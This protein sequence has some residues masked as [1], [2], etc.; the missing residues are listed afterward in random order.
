VFC[1]RITVKLF[2]DLI[3]FVLVWIIAHNWR[4]KLCVFKWQSNRVL[5]ICDE[6]LSRVNRPVTE[7]LGAQGRP[8]PRGGLCCFLVSKQNL[9]TSYWCIWRTIVFG[10]QTKL[11][12]LLLVHV[13]HYCFWCPNKTW[14]P[15][16]GAC[17]ALLFLVSKQNL[18][19]SYW[20][21]WR[22]KNHQK[23]NRIEKV[24]R[25]QNE[26]RCILQF[27]KMCFLYSSFFSGPLALHVKDEL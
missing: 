14:I 9:N 20:C 6:N 15:P 5:R 10:V 4:W 18:N 12:Y 19:T 24:R 27:E 26:K 11:E 16:I 8:D 2:R 13:T 3:L 22:T 1:A 7:H 21:I 17:D 23:Q 25:G